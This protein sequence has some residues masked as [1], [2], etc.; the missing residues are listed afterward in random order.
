MICSVGAGSWPKA[1]PASIEVGET[2]GATTRL[3][4]EDLE[5]AVKLTGG[6]H[7][8]HISDEAAQSAG[9]RGRI[10]HG[11]V[12]AAIMTASIGQRFC[13]HHIALMA[14]GQRYREPVY[15]GD[16][17]TSRWSVLSVEPGRLPGMRVLALTGELRNQHGV[18]VV[19]GEAKVLCRC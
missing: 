12:S 1:V 9:L 8:V 19:E 18:V 6:R 15:P 10:F 3:S 14:Q 17:L 16:T 5:M 2:F 7:P 4:A 13:Q 11:A